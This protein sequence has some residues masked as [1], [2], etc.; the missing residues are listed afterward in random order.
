[1]EQVRY[2]SNQ[3]QK[4]IDRLGERGKTL[5]DC[6]NFYFLHLEQETKRSIVPPI[7]EL[8]Q[9]WYVEKRDSTNR[10]IRTKT[11]NELKSYHKFI[12]DHWGNLKP[13]EVNRKVLNGVYEELNNSNVT[14]RQKNR[15]VRQFFNWCK[16]EGYCSE[17]PADGIKITVKKSEVTILKPSEIVELLRLVEKKFPEMVGFYVL[18]VFG[19][20]RPSESQRVVW[21]DINFEGKEIYVN[22]EGKTGSRRFILEECPET[23]V[24]W[25]WLNHLKSIRG[26]QPFNPTKN[27]EGT[28]K[29]IRS[30]VKFPWSQDVLRHS[31]GTYYYNL[32]HDLGKVVHDMGNSETICK[33]HYVRSV[34]NSDTKEFWGIRPEENDQKPND[35]SLQST[36][37]VRILSDETV[38]S[39]GETSVTC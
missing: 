7:K 14:K 12:I 38:N 8:C 17:N 9:K 20:L 1:M 23:N 19:G 10:P 35:S 33:R 30:I 3:I 24:L 39:N 29:K 22:S 25:V 6:I 11:K 5:D 37:L 4:M 28:Q 27:H 13:F 34:A 16:L 21:D 2:Q 32:I 18:C 15:Y 26:H 31:F 36:P